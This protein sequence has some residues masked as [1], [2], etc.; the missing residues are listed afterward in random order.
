MRAANWKAARDG[1]DGQ[2]I[3]LTG[4][5]RLVPTREFLAAFVERIRPALDSRGEYQR[6]SDEVA[7]VLAEGNGAMRQ[8]R[9]WRRR[10]DVGDVIAAAAWARIS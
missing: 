5:P 9:A 3:D 4:R 7:R 10:E 6:V 2:A 1:L 8:I